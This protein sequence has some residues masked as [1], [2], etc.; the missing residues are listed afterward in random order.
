M[1]YFVTTN[2][3]TVCHTVIHAEYNAETHQALLDFGKGSA[4]VPIASEEEFKRVCLSG[5]FES[6]GTNV[7][8]KMKKDKVADVRSWFYS[9]P[10]HSKCYVM[11]L[12]PK[13]FELYQTDAPIWNI[14]L[15]PLERDTVN[16]H[17]T[18]AV[19]RNFL[20][21]CEVLS[22]EEIKRIRSKVP[23][24]RPDMAH[25]YSSVKRETILNAYYEGMNESTNNQ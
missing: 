5:Y 15:T 14:S 7:L 8:G 1:L 12:N 25:T 4:F 3:N 9:L 22:Q 24:F 11:A 18:Y 2:G 17:S 23:D 16:L 19:I 13:I 6:D 10:A 20:L 21:F